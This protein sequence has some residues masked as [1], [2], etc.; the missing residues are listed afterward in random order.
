MRNIQIALATGLTL[1]ASQSFAADMAEPGP[2]VD[3]RPSI[4]D[5][6]GGYVGGQLGYRIGRAKTKGLDPMTASANPTDSGTDDLDTPIVGL[7]G[8]YDHQVTETIVVGV[9]VDANYGSDSSK[10]SANFGAAS[11]G[12]SRL[13][14]DW[15]ASARLRAGVL[16]NESV[17]VYGTG[18]VAVLG[19]KLSASVVRNGDRSSSSDRRTHLGWTIGAGAEVAIANDWRAFAE[20]RYAEFDSKTYRW[21]DEGVSAKSKPRT[22]TLLT[23]VNYA[24]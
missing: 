5:W 10:K 18:G 2:F 17:L 21:D 15:D 12:E 22:H 24:F 16:L 9:A 14:Q 11:S 3:L 19:E 6:T 1:V 23:G 7:R 4:S 20:Y 13:K 8:G